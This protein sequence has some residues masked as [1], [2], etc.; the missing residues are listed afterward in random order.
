M[1]TALIL[2]A[3]LGALAH[4]SIRSIFT[5]E[6]LEFAVDYLRGLWPWTP[7]II[8]FLL[9]VETVVPP[10]PAWPILLANVAIFGL[11]GGIALSWFGSVLGSVTC[12]WIARSMGRGYAKRL[13]KEEHMEWVDRIS[14][15]KGFQILL[16]AR[17]FPLTSLD[18]LSFVAGLSQMRFWPFLVATALGLLPGVTLYTLFAHDLLELKRHAVRLSITITLMVASFLA[19]RYRTPLAAWWMKIRKISPE[20]E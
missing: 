11:W 14:Q 10:L 13:I 1:I 4:P 2:L 15:E 12:F 6:N 18:I 19:F 9:V 5:A 8:I 16:V 17:I 7:L 20:S 3:S